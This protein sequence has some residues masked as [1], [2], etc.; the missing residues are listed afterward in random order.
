M[1]EA[2]EAASAGIGFGSALAMAIS[3]STN[4]SIG[5]AIVHGVLSWFFVIYAGITYP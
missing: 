5:W 3:Y 2:S 4:H 1:S